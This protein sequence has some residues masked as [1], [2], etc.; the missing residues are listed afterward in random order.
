MNAQDLNQA[1]NHV[2]EG[3]LLELDT[4]D[5]EQTTM[6]TYKKTF[7]ILA[8]AAAIALLSVTA[9]AAD[10]LGIRS[11]ESAGQGTHYRSYAQIQKALSKANLSVNLPETLPEGYTFQEADVDTIRGKD[12]NGHTV[13]TYRELNATYANKSG[14]Q[15][16]LAAYLT[17]EGLPTSNS[18]PSETRTVNGVTMS[19]Q[20]DLYRLVPG[21]YQP[22]PEDEA[23]SRQPNHY[24]TY[25]SPTIQEQTVSFLTWQENG[26]S[27]M[28][29]ELDTTLPADT[30]FSMAETL[31]QG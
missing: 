28:L 13:L 18:I 2:D 19:Y 10:F 1:L 5:K 7:H 12:E 24:I 30:L 29:Y 22:T 14:N 26:T 15:L 17:Q 25:G 4:F 6:K 20:Q 21:D 11:L 16:Y 23:W 27:Y 9:Y 3:Y 31:L 8:L